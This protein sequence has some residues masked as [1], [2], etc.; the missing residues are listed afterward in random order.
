MAS[1]NPLI[2][3]EQPVTRQDLFDMWATGALTEIGIDDFAE[4]F[5]P[6]II[7]SDF[8][9]APVNPQ[10]GSHLWHQSE[11][12]MYVYHDEI[13]NTGVSLWLAIGPDKF[14]TAMMA[15]GPIA[16]GA[17]VELVGP[18]RV[19]QVREAAEANRLMTP[20]TC[21]FNQSHI[22][23]PLQYRADLPELFDPEQYTYSNFSGDDSGATYFYGETAQSGEWIRVGID[24]IMY[25]ASA[26]GSHPSE[27]LS[28]WT[29]G[30]AVCEDTIFPG[31]IISIN[32][33]LSPYNNCIGSTPARS[34]KETDQPTETWWLNRVAFCPK[35]AQNGAFT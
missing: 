5:I 10:P 11:N 12:V 18:G 14:E 6:I 28:S 19:V 9:S 29:N 24:G 23:S 21:G 22:N 1:I 32:S 31:C 34:G 27:S 16:C 4:G 8:S 7:A 3:F 17:G 35:R 30:G 2:S 26:T 15:K 13:D 33:T 25:M 20:M